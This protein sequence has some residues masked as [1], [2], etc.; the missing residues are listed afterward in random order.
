MK[1]Q[2]ISALGLS[3][4]GLMLAGCATSADPIL[5]PPPP[6]AAHDQTTGVHPA[7]S[8]LFK[9][10]LKNPPPYLKKEDLHK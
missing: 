7:H 5:A 3:L 9:K 2:F 6:G 10:D 4:C 1:K 8:P